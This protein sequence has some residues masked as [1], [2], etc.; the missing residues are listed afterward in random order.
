MCLPQFRFDAD[1]RLFSIIEIGFSFDSYLKQ[2]ACAV[3][4]MTAKWENPK[5][6]PLED[7]KSAIEAIK[8]SNGHH[9]EQ[10][11][12]YTK[13]QCER[14]MKLWNEAKNNQE[15]QDEN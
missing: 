2:C 11:Y 6:T 1:L 10:T 14:L 12:L 9:D 4:N 3:Q 7:I 8:N 13:E 5:S 15:S